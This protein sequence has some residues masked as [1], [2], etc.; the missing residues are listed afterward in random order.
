[1]HSK[2]FLSITNSLDLL[3]YIAFVPCSTMSRDKVE[4]GTNA[5][6][7]KTKP[8]TGQHKSPC[9][10]LLLRG[11]NHGLEVQRPNLLE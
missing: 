8:K 7:Q 11:T 1:M 9:N 4:R 6:G 5:I 2:I 3:N 10:G